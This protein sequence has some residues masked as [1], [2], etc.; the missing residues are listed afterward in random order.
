MPSGLYFDMLLVGAIV[1]FSIW[2]GFVA[3]RRKEKNRILV[4]AL[5]LAGAGVLLYL[6]A[7]QWMPS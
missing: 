3:I 6:R 4:I 1:L 5:A 7:P 2:E